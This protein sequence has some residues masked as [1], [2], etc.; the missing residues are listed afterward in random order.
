[1]PLLGSR[2]NS[3]NLAFGFMWC[4]S[5]RPPSDPHIWHVYL[6]LVS[7][8]VLHD[9]YSGVLYVDCACFLVFGVV[10]REGES[11]FGG[12]DFFFLLDLCFSALLELLLATLSAKDFIFTHLPTWRCK[13]VC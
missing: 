11:F 7:I 5:R 10:R 1:M 4:A 12:R 9:L 2:V 6:S 8:Y 3:G 13:G